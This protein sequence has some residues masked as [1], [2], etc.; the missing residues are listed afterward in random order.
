MGVGMAADVHQQRGVVDGGAVLLIEPGELGQP[1][2]DQALPQHVLHR[3]AEAQI[4]A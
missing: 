2:R 1:E 3:L 4:H